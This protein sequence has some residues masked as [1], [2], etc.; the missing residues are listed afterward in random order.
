M[1]VLKPTIMA[2]SRP[3][4]TSCVSGKKFCP[5]NTHYS[6]SGELCYNIVRCKR[7][8]KRHRRFSKNI[9]EW[10]HSG[11]VRSP[12]TRVG[13]TPSWVRI[14]PAPHKKSSGHH[15]LSFFYSAF[16]SI[17]RRDS[18]HSAAPVNNAPINSQSATPTNPDGAIS[19]A[20]ASIN[21]QKVTIRNGTVQR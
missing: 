19:R 17:F 9:L 7:C 21:T 1:D 13:L 15:L 20:T 16:Y 3:L 6:K 18:Y 14:P 4:K 10:S 11:L 8:R 12:G 2:Q 5:Q